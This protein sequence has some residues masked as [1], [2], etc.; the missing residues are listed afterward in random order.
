MSARPARFKQVDVTRACNGVKAA[1]FPVSRVE[2]D[3]SGKIVILC[4][5]GPLPEPANVWDEVLRVEAPH[6]SR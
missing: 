6:V 2:I 1:G 4:A 3:A 5:P